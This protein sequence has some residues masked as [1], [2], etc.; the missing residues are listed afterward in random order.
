MG[1]CFRGVWAEVA[2]G[3]VQ[4]HAILLGTAS[5]GAQPSVPL[6]WQCGWPWREGAWGGEQ[7]CQQ[8]VVMWGA[9]WPVDTH[10]S[11]L[12]Y[13]RIRS[14]TPCQRSWLLALSQPRKTSPPTRACMTQEEA[15]QWA[16]P[17]TS[18]MLSSPP[19]HLFP[20]LYSTLPIPH[21][22]P[23]LPPYT[24]PPTHPRK[25]APHPHRR[26][27]LA[28]V[29]GHAHHR[30]HVDDAPALL[31]AHHLQRILRVRW[32]QVGRLSHWGTGAA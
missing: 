20:P 29:P 24:H 26:A 25:K 4:L 30:R 17:I 3:P 13:L 8:W 32:R 11:D 27:Y 18:P 10:V 14:S 2:A 9:A 22:I 12:S 6:C 16:V 21:T 28:S 19:P 5:I 7:T 15:P 23:P 31:L 1:A